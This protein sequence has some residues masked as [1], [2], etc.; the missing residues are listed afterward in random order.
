[1]SNPNPFQTTLGTDAQWVVFAVM[2]LA[3]IVFSIAVQFRPLPLRLT[4][5]VNIAI[6]TIAATA[7][8]AMAV[9][10]GDN[11]PTAGTGADERQVI[12]ARYIDWVFTTPLLLLDLVLLTNMPATMIAWIMGADIAMIAFGIIGAFTV[13]SYK[14]FYFVV[15]C[16]MLAVLAWGMI[17]PI[18]KEELQKHKEYTGAYTTLLIY[19]I[20]LW[21]IYPIVWGLGAGGHIIGVDVEII[22][23]GVLDLLAKPLYAIGVLITVEVVYGKVGQGGSLAFDCLK[24]LK[25]WKLLW[26]Q[27][28]SIHFSLCVC[29]VTSYFLLN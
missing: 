5:Y 28:V 13:G 23:M 3:A 16:I 15:G 14:W 9:N 1:M 18:F 24:I 7:Y 20:V 29:R 8:Y 11:K 17:N 22:A 6:C 12:Y 19:L 2:A 26:F 21:V 25:W 10:G 27:L 4:Y